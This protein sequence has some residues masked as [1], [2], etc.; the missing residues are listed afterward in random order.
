MKTV[1]KRRCS[2]ELRKM[3]TAQDVLMIPLLLLLFLPIPGCSRTKAPKDPIQTATEA[4]PAAR[5]ISIKAEE[6]GTAVL[7][8]Q[9]NGEILYSFGDVSKKYM[10][11][12]IRKPFLGALYG[13][14]R[15][16]G[17]I[18]LDLSLGELG[19]DDIPPSLTEEEKQ[20]TIRD[21]LLSRSGIYHRAAGEAQSMRDARPPRGSH[22]AGTWFYYNNWD[23]NTLGTIFRQL[24]KQDIFDA[25]SR[26]IARPAEM[27]DFRPS[28]GQYV[29]EREYSRHPAYFFRMSSRDLARFG[30]LY[31]KGGLWKG[32]QIVPADWIDESTRIRPVENPGGD[33]YGYLWRI[34]P[35]ESGLGHAY[36]HMGLG[37]HL[38]LILPDY[39]MVIV[40]RVDTDKAFTITWPQI[41]EL[42]E[43]AF[44]EF[45]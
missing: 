43:L 35:P 39:N 14:Y 7:L 45:H 2:P 11:H 28:D 3:R 30:E 16:R 44:Q 1:K 4:S 27:E 18:D 38:L 23:F 31:L 8:V 13:I 17:M 12:S 15:E 24:T 26:E 5:E 20:A 6:I 33:P 21:L 37:V 42:L 25:F 41:K 22:K 32:Q 19:I 10:C 9:K 40:H 29:Y 36:Y 34:V